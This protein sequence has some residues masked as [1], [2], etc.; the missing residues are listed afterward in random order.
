MR[1]AFGTVA[2][3]GLGYVGLPLAVH[4][5]RLQPTIG[6]EVDRD[7]L[8][9]LRSGNDPA[10]DLTREELAAAR[11]L[12]LTDD[13]R[14]LAEAD[15]ILVAVPTPVNAARSP[16]LGPLRQAS[17]AIGE[18]MKRGAVIVYESTVY[19]GATE[20]VCIPVLEKG[21]GM[22]WKRDFHVGYSPERINP[23]DRE[24]TLTNTVK[25][26]AADDAATL[27]SVSPSSPE[28]TF[29]MWLNVCCRSPGLMR[30]G[31]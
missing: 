17:R 13:A 12:R 2:V 4:F 1:P 30:S 7:K 16:D 14:A 21:S 23:G 11:E 5:G 18:N 10:G 6:L 15:V 20:E 8:A 26:V 3:V 9:A 29:R 24:H 22:K 19:P 25:V 27:S 28:T 31:E